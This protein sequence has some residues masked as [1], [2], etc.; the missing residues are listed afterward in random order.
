MN[1]WPQVGRKYLMKT[2]L[3]YYYSKISQFFQRGKDWN[4]HFTGRQMDDQ[5]ANEKKIFLKFREINNYEITATRLAKI[6]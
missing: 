1:R 4:R 5:Y 3:E 6:F 2:Y